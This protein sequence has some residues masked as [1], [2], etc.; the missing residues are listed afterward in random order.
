[1]TI[2]GVLGE[3][4]RLVDSEREQL[5]DAAVATAREIRKEN[6][7]DFDSNPFHV[8]V[9]VSHSGTAGAVHLCRTAERADAVMLSPLAVSGDGGGG[10]G[11]DSVLHLYERVRDACPTL[12]IVLQD[13]PS[14][15]GVHMS[16][17]LLLRIVESVP[18]VA[19]IKLESMPTLDR[20]AALTEGS[21]GFH[22]A[23]CSILTGLGALYAGFDLA[24]GRT[25]GFMTGFAFPEIL[26]VMHELMK[27]ETRGEGPAYHS[28]L[29]DPAFAVYSHFLP[30]L[31]FEQQP[32]AGLAIRKEIFRRR[33]WIDWARVRHPGRNG[34]SPA[35]DGALT[36]QLRRSFKGVDITQPLSSSLILDLA[37]L[38]PN[39][40]MDEG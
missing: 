27:K 17:Q 7:A 20:I 25:D 28:S 22:A 26:R 3:S 39:N 24:S 29:S 16:S 15:T 23:G 19:C 13:H 31:V 34:L 38:R 21:T 35:L 5:V 1:V 18:T 30:L 8:C 10:G 2:L 6:P 40:G 32:G 12:P 33:G 11:D 4:N 36:A 37:G 14:S 9:G